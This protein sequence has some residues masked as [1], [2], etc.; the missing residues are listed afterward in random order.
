MKKIFT[1]MV[2]LGVTISV[3]IFPDMYYVHQD[4][5]MTNYKKSENYKLDRVEN[6]DLQ[7][8][9]DIM[10]NPDS[11]YVDVT[12][13]EMDHN[14]SNSD[15]TVVDKKKIRQVVKKMN[16]IFC[17]ENLDD[18]GGIKIR[19]QFKVLYTSVYEVYSVNLCD[20]LYKTQN[21]AMKLL[22][23]AE[24][25]IVIYCDI[26]FA[27]SREKSITDQLQEDVQKQIATYY[28]DFDN[29]EVGMDEHNTIL[30]AGGKKNISAILE[31][32]DKYNNTTVEEYG[33]SNL[34]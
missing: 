31:I 17:I 26:N 14:D 4:K 6:I 28:G 30:N 27:D 25:D 7:K 12:M 8:K 29:W 19:R 34:K 16:E 9:I 11:S 32:L 22:Y 23:I 21:F 20:V 1:F 18:K 24:D 5:I 3:I 15:K 33:Y 10:A 2:V 13:S